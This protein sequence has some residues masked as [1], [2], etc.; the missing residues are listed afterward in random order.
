VLNG[1][2]KY[3]EDGPNIVKGK[4]VFRGVISGVVIVVNKLE[5]YFENK[6]FLPDFKPKVELSFDKNKFTFKTSK[7]RPPPCKEVINVLWDILK[8][9][10][11]PFG[12][13][14][15]GQAVMEDIRWFFYEYLL[16]MMLKPIKGK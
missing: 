8:Y 11:R 15:L 3:P 10:I 1:N 7:C 14:F 6:L 2:F 13:T 5:T 16:Q 9:K 12:T 4:F